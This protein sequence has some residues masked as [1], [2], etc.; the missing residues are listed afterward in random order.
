MDGSW[1]VRTHGET[2][3]PLQTRSDLL[4]SP[5]RSSA[6]GRVSLTVIGRWSSH[7]SYELKKKS[8]FLTIGPPMVP[9][10]IFKFVP[11]KIV[12]SAPGVR[13]M[14]GSPTALRRGLRL[15]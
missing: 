4:K 10:Y 14:V 12:S 1:I 8:L 11:R 7:S 9:P 13:T 6:V 2:A 15:W 3:A 5:F